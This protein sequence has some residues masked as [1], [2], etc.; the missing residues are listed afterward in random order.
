MEPRIDAMT[1]AVSDLKRALDAPAPEG[2]IWDKD[3]FTA[4]VFRP[5]VERYR[6]KHS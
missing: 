2:G 1:L 6:R 3:N 5:A 4:R